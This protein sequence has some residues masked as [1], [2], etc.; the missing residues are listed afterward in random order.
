MPP[1]DEALLALV[2]DFYEHVDPVPP[3]VVERAQDAL[4][5]DWRA[6]TVRPP[7][8][9]AIVHGPKNVENRNRQ[10]RRRGPILIHAG[11][12]VDRDAPGRSPA[13]T[14]WL[15]PMTDASNLTVLG[16]VIGAA[17][18]VD[19]HPAVP[20]WRGGCCAPWGESGPGSE[21]TWHWVLDK[22]LAL[23]E[24]VPCKGALGFWRPAPDAL[25][26]VL[27]QLRSVAP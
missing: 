2:G 26:A 15:R 19:C 6:L 9:A 5:Y 21:S 18:I 3:G 14:R 23:P 11:V 10:T 7:W 24:P 4:T 22:R 12:S 17:V 8:S 25:A 1:S 16:A 13:L 20:W 27:R